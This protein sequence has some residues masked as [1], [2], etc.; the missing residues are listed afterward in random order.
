MVCRVGVKRYEKGGTPAYNPD[1][2]GLLWVW[3][4]EKRGYRSIPLDR[5]ISVRINGIEYREEDDEDV[6]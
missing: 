4:L 1:D 2:Y 5:V 6:G 3:D